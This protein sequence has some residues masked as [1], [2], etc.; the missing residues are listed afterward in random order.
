[1]YEQITEASSEILLGRDNLDLSYNTRGKSGSQEQPFENSNSV[2][3]NANLGRSGW[4]KRR[5][6]SKV[7]ILGDSHGGEVRKTQGPAISWKKRAKQGLTTSEFSAYVGVSDG[8]RKVGKMAEEGA[9]TMP[10]KGRKSTKLLTQESEDMAGA[11]AQPRP[12]QW[13]FWAGTARG[14]GTPVQFTPSA[15]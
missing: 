2:K 9:S 10:K 5:K 8:K 13:L 3:E 6:Q 15:V 4:M 12:A 14:L 1:M 11:V 7:A